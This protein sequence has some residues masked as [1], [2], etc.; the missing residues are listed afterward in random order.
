MTEYFQGD[1]DLS[2]A[3]TAITPRTKDLFSNVSPIRRQGALHEADEQAEPED[4]L[5]ADLGN[6]ENDDGGY[7]KLSSWFFAAAMANLRPQNLPLSAIYRKFYYF[8]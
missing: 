4:D 8:S 1:R 6:D 5:A 3:S 7:I 2:A